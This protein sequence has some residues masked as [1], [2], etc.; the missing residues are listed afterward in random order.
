MALEKKEYPSFMWELEQRVKVAWKNRKNPIVKDAVTDGAKMGGMA[1]AIG[2][3][4]SLLMKAPFMVGT[5]ITQIFTGFFALALFAPTAIPAFFAF[6]HFKRALYNEKM[7]KVMER[8][9]EEW[10]KNPDRRSFV[11]KVIG[12]GLRWGLNGLA[13]AGGVA[14]AAGV[15]VAAAAGIAAFGG[16]A[17]AGTAVLGVATQIVGVT[18][19]AIGVVNPIA[20]MVAGVASAAVGTGVAWKGKA[21]VRKWGEKLKN[22][23]QLSES[24]KEETSGFIHNVMDKGRRMFVGLAA[25]V[26][27]TAAQKQVNKAANDIQ[28]RVKAEKTKGYSK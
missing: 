20:L 5:A 1:T 2:F 24:G 21:T 4:T 11:G 10:R 19:A 22:S 17:L 25:D 12:T 18:A 13:I 16:A 26:F 6:R 15:T 3:G 7:D 8:K 28:K 14:A 23:L 9:I 27:N